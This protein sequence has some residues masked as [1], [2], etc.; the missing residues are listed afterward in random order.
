[1]IEPLPATEQ[2]DWLHPLSTE[3]LKVLTGATYRQLD[4]W[5]RVGYLHPVGKSGSGHR[6]EY[7]P[8]EAIV[9][10]RMAALTAAGLTPRIAHDFARGDPTTVTTLLRAIQEA[11]PHPFPTID[12]APE[13]CS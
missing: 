11:A 3:E 13:E 2:D 12:H 4:F 6:R 7:P 8:A 5:T 9:A 1:M 10:A